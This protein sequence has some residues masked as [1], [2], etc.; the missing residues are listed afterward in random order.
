MIEV[1]VAGFYLSFDR[2]H[3]SLAV[4]DDRRIFILLLRRYCFD[5]PACSWHVAKQAS[6]SDILVITRNYLAVHHN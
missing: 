6:A 1:E 5:F 3:S 4:M 2:R